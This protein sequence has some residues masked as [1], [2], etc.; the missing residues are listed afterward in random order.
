MHGRRVFASRVDGAL[1]LLVLLVLLPPVAAAAVVGALLGRVP[2]FPGRGLVLT[3]LAATGLLVLWLLLATRYVLEAG[4]L[5]V[6]S[7]PFSWN[8]AL[9]DITA[10]TRTRDPHSAP[11]LS[12]QRLRIEYGA[13]RSIMI[14]PAAEARFLTELRARGVRVGPD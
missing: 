8:I 5:S 10:V 3:A 4:S 12:L 1:V 6:R 7:G 11:A 13:G 2:G 9:G 14:S